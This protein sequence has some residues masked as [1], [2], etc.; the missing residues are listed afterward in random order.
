[1]AASGTRYGTNQALAMQEESTPAAE[2]ETADPGAG[3]DDA[4]A[5]AEPDDEGDEEEDSGSSSAPSTDMSLSPGQPAVLAQGLV[6]IPGG[7]LVWSVSYVDA[8]D[9]DDAESSSGPAAMFLQREGATIIR[10]DVTGKRAKIEAGEGFFRAADDAY[11]ISADGASSTFWSFELTDEDGVQESARYEGPMVEGIDE[12]TYDMEMV[13]YILEPGDSVDVPTF[14]GTGLIMGLA[15]EI[16]VRNDTV[17]S[18]KEGDGKTL[19]ADDEGASVSNSGSDVAMFVVV[20]LGDEVSDETAGAGTAN[21]PTAVATAET[22]ETP[23]TSVDAPDDTT[24]TE[25]T[26]SGLVTSINIT[27]LNEIYITVTVDGSVAYDGTL[28]AGQST[29]PIIGTNFEVYTSSGESTQFTNACGVSFNMGYETG[30]AS[31]V[32]AAAPDS[33][34][35]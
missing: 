1:L 13:R 4:E 33:C 11:A 18:L 21:Q 20:V 29:G 6:Y 3:E 2:D 26:D 10:N 14:N 31:Y 12:A 7:D 28:A 8:P 25:S 17:T 27:A 9:L 22:Q 19:D 32:L 24:T 30:E 35:P 16:E 5:T 23:D 15:G 34:A